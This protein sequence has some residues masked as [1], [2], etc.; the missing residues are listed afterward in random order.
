[1]VTEKFVGEANKGQKIYYIYS[2]HIKSWLM[3]KTK[4]KPRVNDLFH[5]ILKD[6]DKP[7]K[8]PRN[9]QKRLEL[10]PRRASM[11]YGFI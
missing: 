2:Y 3:Y 8:L 7:Y 4:S 5:R 1:M 10:G 9:V 11:N 6:S